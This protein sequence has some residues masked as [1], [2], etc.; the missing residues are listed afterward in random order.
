MKAGL[1]LIKIVLAPLARS[2]LLPCRLSAAMSAVDSAIQKK[3]WI[4]SY[5][6]N[7]FKWRNARYNE[8]S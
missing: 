5:S 7:N 3:S 8:N 1:A 4:R 6:S 2:V